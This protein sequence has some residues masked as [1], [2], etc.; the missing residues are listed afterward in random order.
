MNPASSSGRTGSPGTGSVVPWLPHPAPGPLPQQ[1][2]AR[3]PKR[4]GVVDQLSDHCRSSSP[5][6][7]RNAHAFARRPI[8]CSTSARSPAWQRL[9]A[10]CP[11]LSRSLVRRSPPARSSSHGAGP[12]PEPS[13]KQVR[14]T[15][16]SSGSPSPDSTSSSCSWQL[17]GQPPSRQTRSPQMVDTARPLAVWGVAPGVARAPHRWGSPRAATASRCTWPAT[18]WG[19]G[20]GPARASKVSKL[21]SMCSTTTASASASGGGWP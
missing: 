10:R 9:H 20:S 16:G 4:S 7:R 6:Q 19:L 1:D 15:G 5:R 18:S 2:R 3:P 12:A 13:V 14:D 17:P 11:A 8:A 21:V